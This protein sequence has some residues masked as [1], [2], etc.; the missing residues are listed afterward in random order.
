M[1]TR[2]GA[3]LPKCVI[4]TR[5]MAS[6]GFVAASANSFAPRRIYLHAI[7]HGKRLVAKAEE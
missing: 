5:F 1:N 7:E 3:P 4:A 6:A 2:A